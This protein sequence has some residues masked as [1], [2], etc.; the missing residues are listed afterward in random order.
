MTWDLIV[1][2]GGAAG[3]WAA[4]TAASRGSRV[5]VLEKNKKAGVKILISGGTRCNITHHCGIAGIL[6]AF[7]T[8]GRF[9]KPALHALPPNE[10]VAEFNRLGVATKVE[11]TGKVFPVSDR[12]I[13]VRDAL[14]ARLSQN[15][16]QLRTGI[17]VQDLSQLPDGGWRVS[18][19]GEQLE[20]QKVLLCCGGLSYPGCGTTGDGYAWAKR[21]GHTIEQTHA[22]LTPLLSPS[23]W[24]HE[25]SGLTLS[26]A[27]VTVCPPMESSAGP[28]SVDPKK[29]SAQTKT[30]PKAKRSKDPRLT[31][32]GGFLWTHFGCSGPAPMNVSR[33]VTACAEPHRAALSIDLTP[34]ID[35]NKLHAS[36]DASRSG[37]QTVGSILSQWL[38][39]KLAAVLLQNA[40]TTA[41]T[42][43]AELPKA[44][45][46]QLIKDLKSLNVPLSGSRGYPKAEVTAGGVALSEVNPK[47]LES[48]KVSGLFFAGEILNFDGPIGGFNFQ[49]A[50]STG[51]LAALAITKEQQIQD[52]IP[53]RS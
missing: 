39:K 28:S 13:D 30:T 9:L 21:V 33:F 15:G 14:V 35:D 12:A 20:A 48:R 22:A 4:G 18:C 8:Q 38:P 27:R 19:E 47:T 44:S 25:L 52:E 42:K 26:D 49:A 36:F 50:F 16:A 7:G 11:D 2:G 1:I 6:E 41:D 51:H 31:S 46:L 10:V 24:V 43:L 34:D 29:P 3:L 32:R 23:T 37:R 45:R 40:S 5:L 53:T 17:A